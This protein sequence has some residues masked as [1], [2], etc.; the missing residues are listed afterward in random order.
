[1]RKDKTEG[2]ERERGKS[3]KEKKS[4]F[5][6]SDSNLNVNCRQM[7]RWSNMSQQKQENEGTK[8]YFV[9]QV[10][11]RTTQHGCHSI[12]P[13]YP[14]D[15]RPWP[16]WTASHSPGFKFNV[17]LLHWG[18]N[19]CECQQLFLFLLLASFPRKTHSRLEW[20]SA[21]ILLF[22]SLCFF[23]PCFRLS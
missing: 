13:V 10:P 22:H 2:L 5:L 17:V 6:F 18:W 19:S 15:S 16:A 4:H 20:L 8:P 23:P 14:G 11:D 3:K 9:G 1:M 12:C 7:S 21:F